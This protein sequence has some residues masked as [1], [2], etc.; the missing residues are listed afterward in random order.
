MHAL[1]DATRVSLRHS[2]NREDCLLAYLARGRLAPPD[3]AR[4]TGLREARV[5]AALHGA[6]PDYAGERALVPLGLVRPVLTR[7][8]VEHELTGRGLEE[9][10]AVA[11]LRAANRAV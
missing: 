3:V 11:A 10:R 4:E 7:F 9:A 8:G 1:R 5:L 6:M 2:R